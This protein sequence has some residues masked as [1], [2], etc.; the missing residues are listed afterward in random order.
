MKKVQDFCFGWRWGQVVRGMGALLLAAS[1]WAAP[2]RPNILFIAIDDLRTW[3][4]CYGEGQAITPNLDRLARQAMRFSRAYC[5]APL[6]NPSR[7]ALI[8]GMRPST[9]GVYWNTINW[10]RALPNVMTIP[11]WFKQHGYYVAGAG[12]ITHARMVRY[13]DWDDFGPINDSYEGEDRGNDIT[14]GQRRREE[15]HVGRFHW[16]IVPNNHEKD[17]IDYRITSYV[18]AKLKRRYDRPFFLACGIHRPHVPWN[19]PKKYFDL[20]P[21]HR[22]HQP[23]INPHDLDDVSPVGRRMAHPEVDEAIRRVP[24]GPE[25]V[26]QAYLA[27]TSFADAQI[28]RLLDA[29]E[30]SP[31]RDNTIIVLWS[32][33]GWHH[34]E[35]QHWAKTVLWEEATRAPMMWMVPGLTRPGSVCDRP[36]D[37]TCIFPTL[38]D[39][40]GLPIPKQCEGVSIRPLLANPKAEWNRPA[41]STMGYMN[42]AVRDG[43]WR[44]IRYMDGSEELYDHQTDP[45]EWV[46]LAGRPEYASIKARL[47]KWLPKKN[48]FRRNPVRA[49]Q[50]RRTG[51]KA[52]SPRSARH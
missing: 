9:T 14:G 48:V 13:S 29:L 38:C 39:L 3:V 51:S 28:G 32:D 43:R 10:I 47:A 42:H 23:K 34:G 44:Y 46:N 49:R 8:T 30:R 52:Q 6:C 24:H 40:A 18:I 50:A 45:L 16:H 2:K 25:K 27:A 4:G 15:I 11:L 33:H 36:V 1:L 31:Y 26:I 20:Y 37:Y 7:T 17:L 22:V 41:V 35:K 19:V 5:A 21:L 12:K